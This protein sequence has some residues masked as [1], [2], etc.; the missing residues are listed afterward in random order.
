[1]HRVPVESPK[2]CQGGFYVGKVSLEEFRG[3]V[4]VSTDMCVE[5][6]LWTKIMIY[7][8][9]ETESNDFPNRSIL[10]MEIEVYYKYKP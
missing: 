9:N 4:C 7:L 5:T 1:M 8:F 10:K 2:R 6:L 3:C